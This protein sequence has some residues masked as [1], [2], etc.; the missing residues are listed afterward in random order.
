MHGFLTSVHLSARRAFLL[1]PLLL[2]HCNGA[3]IAH[4]GPASSDATAPDALL[5]DHWNN[6][7]TVARIAMGGW[8]AVVF[9]GHG[10]EASSVPNSSFDVHAGLLAGVATDAGAR[11]VWF[12]TWA[13]RADDP[14]YGPPDAG[15]T[16]AVLTQLTEGA[17]EKV[18]HDFGGVVAR[19][20][21]VWQLALAEQPGVLLHADDGTHPSPA[22]TLLTACVMLLTLTGQ[23][24]RL[25]EPPPLGVPSA[26]A[27]AL[28][29]LAERVR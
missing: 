27:S 21:A 12:A 9:Q 14:I 5:Q 19:V 1:A 22:G 18:A 8:G 7:D 24:P 2:A 16:P 15:I 26:T 17:Y 29:A 6:A 4:D 23:N 13:R 20:G 28:C 25:P 3:A 10:L 11:P